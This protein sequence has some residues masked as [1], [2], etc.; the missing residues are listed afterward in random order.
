MKLPLLP[1][2]PQFAKTTTAHHVLVGD[3]GPAFD[4]MDIA[5]LS[6]AGKRLTRPRSRQAAHEGKNYEYANAVG[7]SQGMGT[8][9]NFA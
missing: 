7:S 4:T 5:R 2:T 8:L 1:G 9:W 3:P 6:K